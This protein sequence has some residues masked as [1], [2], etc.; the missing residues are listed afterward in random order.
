MEHA[1]ARLAA[2]V[3]PFR[4]LDFGAW[5]GFAVGLPHV[6]AALAIVA[7]LVCALAGARHGVD[8]VTAPLVGLLFALGIAPEVQAIVN[9]LMPVSVK[10]V[11]LVL[12]AAVALLSVFVPHA[13]VFFVIGTLGAAGGAAFVSEKELLLG[14]AP[15]FLIAGA[16]G[17]VLGRYL[18]T[19]ITAAVGGILFTGGLLALL[20]DNAI[21]RV[22]TSSAYLPLGLAGL[23]TLAG[24]SL[25]FATYQDAGERQKKKEAAREKK[26]LDKENREREK[27]FANYK[28]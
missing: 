5:F 19:V 11:S 13:L 12:P 17:L 14:L 1:L 26:Q 6:P 23:L 3:E 24:A 27:R 28:R 4:H 21:G 20:G 7:G 15:G 8:R 18:A 9:P 16:I 25:Q 10:L 2:A 22:L